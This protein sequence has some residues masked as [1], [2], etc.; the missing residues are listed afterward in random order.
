MLHELKEQNGDDDDTPSI[1][2]LCPTRWTVRA[3]SLASTIANYNCIQDLWEKALV[4]TTDTEIKARIRGVA[5]QMQTFKFFFC[6]VLSELILRQ[7]DKLSQTLQQP[8][9]SSVEAHEVVMKTLEKICTDEDF[10]LFWK[11]VGIKKNVNIDELRKRKAPKR[12]E[13]GSAPSEF[14]ASVE[15]Y[16]RQIFFEALDL[17][18]TSIKNRF[19]HKGY[20]TF[21]QLEQLLFK[22]CTGEN[23]ETAELCLQLFLEDFNKDELE[24]LRISCS[25]Q[26]QKMKHHQLHLSKLPYYL[27][28]FPKECFL[29]QSLGHFNY[30]LQ[31]IRPQK[32]LSVPFVT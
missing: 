29:G 10:E 22:A 12:F 27:C 9:L 31:P 23:F 6:L 30:Y 1:R 28:L 8:E 26:K 25:I 11:N 24:A 4:S 7:T 2:T 17:A 21:S 5:S 15:D 32:N 13:T 14:P 16:Y 3:N 19:D 18:L 20:Q